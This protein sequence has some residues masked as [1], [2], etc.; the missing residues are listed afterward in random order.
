MTS[1]SVNSRIDLSQNP[2]LFYILSGQQISTTD[3]PET[4]E[5]I[6]AVWPI[7]LF[8]RTGPYS[9]NYGLSPY[10]MGSFLSEEEEKEREWVKLVGFDF[11]S[12]SEEKKRFLLQTAGIIRFKERLD[13]KKLYDTAIY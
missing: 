3:T 11:Y 12:L 13:I 2:I 1:L 7:E 9:K 5:F 6:N 8:P 4:G 10:V